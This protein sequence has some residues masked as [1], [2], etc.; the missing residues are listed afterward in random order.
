[1]F[2]EH[3]KS[4]WRN[5]AKNKTQSIINIAGL[6]VG[7]AVAML[8]GLWIRDE[9]SFDKYHQNYGRI[10]QVMESNTINGVIQTRKNIEPPLAPA[11]QKN[12][13]SDFKSIVMSS[14]TD[15]HILSTNDKAV[16]YTGNF[17][18]PAAPEMFTLKMRSGTRGGLNDP[19]SILLSSTVASSLFGNDEAIGKVIK[20]DNS[21]SL[22]VTGVY[23]D[24]PKNTSLRDISFIAPW[25]Y[26]V[27]SHDWVKN[28]LNDWHERS[29]QLYVELSDKADF[30]KVS[31]KIKDIKLNNVN[32]E[33]AKYNPLILLHP[34]SKWHLYGEFK[35]GVTAGGAIEYVWMFGAIGIFV[36]LL[37]C[38]NFMNLST[39]RSERRAKEI[40]IRKTIGSLRIELI[41]QFFCESLLTAVIAFFIAMILI[42]ISLPAF[43]EL[44][45]K[46]VSIPWLNFIF[47][48]ACIAFTLFTGTIAG[49][50]PALY[51]SSFKPL[52][53]L[54]GT[55]KAGRSSVLPRRILVTIQFTVSIA[56]II[57]TVIVFKQIQFAKNRPVG[58]S[59]SGLVNLE[60]NTE[61][62]ERHFAA[63][64]SELHQAGAITS[65]AEVSTPMTAI[66]SS[67]NDLTWNEKNPNLTYDFGNIRITSGY[68]KTIGWQVVEGRDFSSQLPTDSSSLILNEAAVKYMGLRRPLRETIRYDD[69]DY[70]VI[71]VVKDMVMESPYQSAKQTIFRLSSPGFDN[72]VLRINPALSAHAAL[73][74]IG[75]IWKKY[76]P[77]V[78]FDYRFVDDTYARKFS[79][80][81]RIGSLA[82]IFCLL[83]IFISCFGLFG[84]AT[85]MAAQRTKEVGVRKVLGAS[86]FRL[87]TLLSREFMMLV[88][89]ASFIAIPV[90]YS[91]MRAWLQNYQY[92]TGLSVW[93]FV[94]A[95]IGALVIT[96]LT[97]SFQAIKAAIANP[98][99]TLR[100]E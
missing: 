33:E 92:R 1:M 20:I 58:Y 2:K 53:V 22:K 35:N 46:N 10:A 26:Y 17:M 31:A 14:W 8:I 12:Y 3:V 48:M 18:S 86:V 60:V 52:K 41:N 50:Y 37:A 5:L 28:A 11:L 68:G 57:G 84:M 9:L 19:S 44:A 25:D 95:G 90:A 74:R 66:H 38:I 36:L 99:K 6:S 94:L 89:I 32:N 76:A 72:I 88:L 70:V 69:K 56:L 54:K 82:S 71:G 81:L 42:K 62:V 91:F 24:L 63:F 78:P 43:N 65:I 73:S 47:W 29:F 7:M 67:T 100:T 85:F 16:T 96:L 39:A 97:V 49:L 83:T 4:A 34:M 61:D 55:F 87:W 51:L 45:D 98:V 13:G 15:G 77:S 30:R 59:S 23:E 40:G 93:V 21:A 75:S 64:E 80:E 79:S 27:A